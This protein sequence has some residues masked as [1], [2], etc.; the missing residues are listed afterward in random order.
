MIPYPY[1]K[2]FKDETNYLMTKALH[3]KYHC[4]LIYINA[5]VFLFNYPFFIP[6]GPI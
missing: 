6:C 1:K 3:F 4:C 5:M 2:N